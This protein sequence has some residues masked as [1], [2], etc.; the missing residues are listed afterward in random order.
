ML[1]L[2][3]IAIS[4]WC[5]VTLIACFYLLVQAIVQLSN[6]KSKPVDNSLKTDAQHSSDCASE[7]GKEDS[8]VSIGAS[9]T[10]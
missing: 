4:L 10:N 8:I 1:E 6:Q 3:K 5:A 9:P 2:V 7:S